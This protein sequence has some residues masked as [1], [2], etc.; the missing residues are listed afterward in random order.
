VHGKACLAELIFR[1]DKFRI[2]SDGVMALEG[3]AKADPQG[4]AE[5]LKEEQSDS[6]PWTAFWAAFHITSQGGDPLS[7][8]ADRHLHL[9]WRCRAGTPHQLA[10]H[11][12]ARNGWRGPRHRLDGRRGLD[13]GAK[14]R[15]SPRNSH[16]LPGFHPGLWGSGRSGFFPLRSPFRRFYVKSDAERH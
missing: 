10:P 3:W 4:A 11:G 12:C 2:R 13:G 16:R 14:H 6:A 1:G 5:W 9:Q 8:T 15:T 7:A